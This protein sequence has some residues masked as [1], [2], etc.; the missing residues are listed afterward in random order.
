MV[1]MVMVLV[2]VGVVLLAVYPSEVVGYDCK[3]Y[4]DHNGNTIR[5]ID[6]YANPD[7]ASLDGCQT[8]CDNY[9]GCKGVVWIPNQYGWKNGVLCC[10]LKKKIGKLQNQANRVTCKK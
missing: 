10:F 5:R 7:A 1:A 4:K 2:A 6:C 3:W 8:E 9:Y